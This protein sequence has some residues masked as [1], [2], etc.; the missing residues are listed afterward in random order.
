[1]DGKTAFYVKRFF[2]IALPLLLF[3][4]L[5]VRRHGFFALDGLLF[6][7]A[8]FGFLAAAALVFLSKGLRALLT[9]RSEDADV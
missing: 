8:W 6:F 1:M 4:E 2:M 5:F 9:R 7:E 3:A